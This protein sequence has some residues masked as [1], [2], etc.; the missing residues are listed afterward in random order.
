MGVSDHSPTGVVVGEFQSFSPKPFKYFGFWAEKE[1]FLSLV[2]E[3]WSINVDGIPMY[4]L[5]KKLKAVTMKILK[6]KNICGGLW[7]HQAKSYS[8]KVSA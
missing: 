8:S 6:V 1:K 3:G 2:E 5:Y 4:R 7:K